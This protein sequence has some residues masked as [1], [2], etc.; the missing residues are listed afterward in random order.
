MVYTSELNHICFVDKVSRCFTDIFL[1][2]HQGTYKDNSKGPTVD[3]S[4]TP[5]LANANIFK[6]ASDTRGSL[7]DLVGTRTLP[8][9]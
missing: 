5:P 3:Q 8:V 7:D 1:Q 4:A 6:L 2:N 9:E